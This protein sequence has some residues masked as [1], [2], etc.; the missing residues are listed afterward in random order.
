MIVTLE[1][2]ETTDAAPFRE[3]WQ[4]MLRGKEYAPYHRLDAV[5]TGTISTTKVQDMIYEDHH[6]YLIH[7][8]QNETIHNLGII[9][10][11]PIR[12]QTTPTPNFIPLDRTPETLI[13]YHPGRCRVLDVAGAQT[14]MQTVQLALE[15]DNN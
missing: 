1:A 12:L 5:S 4:P 14:L 2:P 13:A 11:Q 7:C 6:T 9:V 8:P 10:T 3:A 15:A